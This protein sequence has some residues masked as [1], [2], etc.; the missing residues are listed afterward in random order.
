ME[1]KA[2]GI[3]SF[4]FI[5][6]EILFRLVYGS[7]QLTLPPWEDLDAEDRSVSARYFFFLEAKL[8]YNLV[9]SV[10]H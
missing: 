8:L 3:S 2:K 4:F 1:E 10:S 5:Y 6:D 7:E 9:V